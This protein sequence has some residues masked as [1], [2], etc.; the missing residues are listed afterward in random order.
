VEA[1]GQQAVV[2]EQ[3]FSYAACYVVCVPRSVGGVAW[4]LLLLLD[5]RA[6]NHNTT[7]DKEPFEAT[8]DKLDI[9]RRHGRYTT[10]NM[11]E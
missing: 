11:L 7:G 6:M 9:D 4:V 2:P 3:T 5:G 10:E 1:S 8:K